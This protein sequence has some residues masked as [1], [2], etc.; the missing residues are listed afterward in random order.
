MIAPAS[1]FW[2]NPEVKN[3]EF[4]IE[5]GRKTLAD[6]GYSWDADGKLRYPKA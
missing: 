4:S 1:K 2:S 6:A 3:V 5:K